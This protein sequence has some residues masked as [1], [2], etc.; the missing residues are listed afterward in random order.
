VEKKG[1]IPMAQIYGEVTVNDPNRLDLKFE[2]YLSTLE[3]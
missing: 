1:G 3:C 2:D